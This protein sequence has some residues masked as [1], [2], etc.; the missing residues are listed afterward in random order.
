MESVSFDIR[1]H[2]MHFSPKETFEI[3]ILLWLY[4]FDI[5]EHEKKHN[6]VVL[7]NYI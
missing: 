4:Y 5:T 3:Y 2:Q 1:I 6:D 7:H